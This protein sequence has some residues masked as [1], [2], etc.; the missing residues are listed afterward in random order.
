MPGPGRVRADDVGEA[1]VEDAPGR[2]RARGARRGSC[3]RRT[4]CPRRPR[5]AA[6]CSSRPRAPPAG[7]VLGD[8]AAGRR[9]QPR[10]PLELVDHVRV[11]ERATVG[12]VERPD[13]HAA[14]GGADRPRLRRERV[15]PVGHP[16]EPDLDVLE[17]DPR[18][19]CATP[20][21]WLTGRGGPPRS[22]A[23]SNRSLGEL[24]VLAL[25]LLDGE[26]VDVAALQPGLDAVDAGAD[27]VD[28][29]GGD[30]HRPSLGRA[31]LG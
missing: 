5:P 31:A 27:G 12:D 1:G 10:Q 7:G 9:A 23:P 3:P 14:A 13:P 6:R 17:P 26:H 22:R 21:H 4:P 16:V 20:F 30:A 19:R 8:P 18:D 2:R 29:P 28:V 11:V 24:V 15:A 25:G